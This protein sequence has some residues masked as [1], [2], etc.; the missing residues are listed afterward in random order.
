MNRRILVLLISITTILSCNKNKVEKEIS[1]KPKIDFTYEVD[2]NTKTVSFTNTSIG[3]EDYIWLFE[4]GK[5][6]NKES[7]IHV[8][9]TE[10]SFKVDL[11]AIIKDTKQKTHNEQIIIIGDKFENKTK[12]SFKKTENIDFAGFTIVYDIKINSRLTALYIE[13]SKDI[14]FSN[15]IINKEIDITTDTKKC[16]I[17][18][19][20]PSTKY[21]Y[22]MSIKYKD[23]TEKDLYY[24]EQKEILTSDLP[25]PSIKLTVNKDDYSKFNVYTN[26]IISKHCTEDIIKYKLAISRSKEFKR[27][28]YAIP[29]KITELLSIFNSDPKTKYF[30][31]YTASYKNVT[32]K[33]E[34]TYG[35]IFSYYYTYIIS[36]D[37]N[38]NI[39]HKSKNFYGDNIKTKR[40]NNKTIIEITNKD[41]EKLVFQIKGFKGLGKYTLNYR[42]E[43]GTYAYF[44]DG[45]SDKKYFLANKEIFLQVFRQ[46]DEFY[47]IEICD[48][49]MNT[50]LYFYQIKESDEEVKPYKICNLNLVIKR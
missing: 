49:R 26:K 2:D 43:G 27:G 17:D 12:V 11:S 22:R 16:T 18:N 25:E 31:R 3:A 4:D 15:I 33:I 35:T 7:P 24:S 44:L 38:T 6:S 20:E 23:D 42:D 39:I 41:K 50:E 37:I 45:K 28:Y 29:Y 21:W 9:E 30:I 8:F 46:S 14:N 10:G 48:S 36:Q 40:D 34:K 13:V 32:S 19:L 47:Y 1:I 5:I